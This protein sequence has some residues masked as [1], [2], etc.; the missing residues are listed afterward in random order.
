MIIAASILLFTLLCMLLAGDHE[1]ANVTRPERNDLVFQ[2]RHRDY[3]AYVLRRE[4]DR[5]VLIALFA[6]LGLLGGSIALLRTLSASGTIEVPSIPRGIDVDL[7]QIFTPPPPAPETPPSTPPTGGGTPTPA[8]ST[9]L[10]LDTA[11]FDERDTTSAPPGPA[12]DT[13]AGRDPGGDP[14]PVGPPGGGGGNGP[15]VPTTIFDRSDIQELPV[16]PGGDAA[17]FAWLQRHMRYP[18]SM[19]DAGDE[20]RVYVEFVVEPDGSVSLVKAVKGRFDQSKAEAVRVV[21]RF[22]RWT[23]GRMNGNPVRCR[24][25]LPVSFRLK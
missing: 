21:G 17:M 18:E 19:V 13:L 25:T 10:V 16:F 3:G 23:P 2:G 14:G 7:T 20:D 4:Y 6:A 5:R 12:V 22:P 8:V 9:V 24:L 1:W 11:R 15:F